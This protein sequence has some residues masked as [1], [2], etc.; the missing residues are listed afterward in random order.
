MA[1]IQYI[2]EGKLHLDCKTS[3]DKP[4][5]ITWRK[6]LH[7]VT[8]HSGGQHIDISKSQLVQLANATNEIIK[9]LK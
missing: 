8:L 3:A 6:G 9:D 4:I 5:A 7:H 2:T 1:D